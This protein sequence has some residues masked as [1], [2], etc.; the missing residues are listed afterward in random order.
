MDRLKLHAHHNVEKVYSGINDLPS[1]S[2]PEGVIEGCAV[3]EGRVSGR[4]RRGRAGRA[5]AKW[6][7]HELHHRRIGGRHERA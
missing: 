3:L 4:L 7:Q 2:A 6:H 1:G 5:D